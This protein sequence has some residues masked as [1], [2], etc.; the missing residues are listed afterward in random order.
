M[1]SN[2][3]IRSVKIVDTIVESTLD[4]ALNLAQ[5]PTGQKKSKITITVKSRINR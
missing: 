1:I 4:R 5:E 2:K 3:L